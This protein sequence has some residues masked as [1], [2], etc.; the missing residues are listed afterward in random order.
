VRRF[1][2]GSRRFEK[3]FDRI[4]VP[5]VTR[6]CR[7][8]R[9]QKQKRDASP[10]CFVF[11]CNTPFLFFFTL[12]TVS[13]R[14]TD[15]PSDL[16]QYW[17]RTVVKTD[18]NVHLLFLNWNLGRFDGVCTF[19]TSTSQGPSV[20]RT[21]NDSAVIRKPRI[22]LVQWQKKRSLAIIGRGAWC[23]RILC[24]SFTLER[25]TGWTGL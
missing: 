6:H 17:S 22:P 1:E 3:K 24:L 5:K 11:F 12:V 21:R 14:R 13:F 18:P 23:C 2:A 16:S 10:S 25:T 7:V 4:L 15:D 9:R 19:F 8:S 20:A